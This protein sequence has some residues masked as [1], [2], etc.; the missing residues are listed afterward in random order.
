L[1]TATWQNDYHRRS[2]QFAAVG[3]LLFIVTLLGYLTFGIT[4]PLNL[5]HGFATVPRPAFI[6]ALDPIEAVQGGIPF[7]RAIPD[8][9]PTPSV[10]VRAIEVRAHKV[11]LLQGGVVF[12]TANLRSDTLPSIVSAVNDHSWLTETAPGVFRLSVALVYETGVS[13]SLSPP[14]VRTIDLADRSGTM[15]GFYFSKVLLRDVLITSPGAKRAQPLA[16]RFRPYVESWGANL[17]VTDC[18]FDDL[19][20]DWNSSYGVSF[21]T[22]ST[23]RVSDSTFENNFI[24]VYTYRSSHITFDGD[25]FLH[26]NLYGLDP[27]T[28]SSQLTIVHNIAEYNGAHGIIFSEHV[29]KSLVADNTS[30]H[31]GENGIMMDADSNGNVIEHNLSA[32][33]RG[34]GVVLSNSS[35]NSIIGNT[36]EHNRIGI[37]VYG[38]ITHAPSASGNVITHNV[39]SVQGFSFDLRDNTTSDNVAQGN[40]APPEWH[41]AID[42]GL[43][44]L[45]ALLF[46]AAVLLRVGERRRLPKRARALT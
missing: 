9:Y 46:G 39:A 17:N 5:L 8:H 23:G 36:L 11:I 37:N 45:T 20:W 44:P 22:D 31:N 14:L 18:T 13:V 10:E 7:E 25:S 42:Y 3:V 30:E 43:W 2:S 33:N 29:T 21:M 16:P 34:D 6:P 41:L 19:G 15:I 24:G 38:L 1:T 26:N 27:H 12:R 32:H 40:E 35:E 4:Q 28:Y